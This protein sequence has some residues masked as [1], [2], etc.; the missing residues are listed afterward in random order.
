MPK[1]DRRADSIGA[2]RR[3]VQGGTFTETKEIK[4]PFAQTGFLCAVGCR[5]YGERLLRCR[6]RDGDDRLLPRRKLDGHRA[7]DLLRLLQI[8]EEVV[9]AMT[10]EGT[11]MPQIGQHMTLIRQTGILGVDPTP[12]G[13]ASLRHGEGECLTDKYIGTK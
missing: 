2:V 10:T 8:E 5:C 7:A 6:A 1:A 4:R 13:C 3:R 11:L 9:V 12:K